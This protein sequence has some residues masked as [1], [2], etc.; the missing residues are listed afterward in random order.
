MTRG[1][2]ALM[3]AMAMF[4]TAML[5]AALPAATP[6][7]AQQ[8]YPARPVRIVMPL[9]AG[10]ALDII[11]RLVGEAMST[12]LGQ[13]VVVENRVGGTGLAAARAAAAA[14]PD[15]YTL[16]GGAA[17]IFT[18]LAA[19]KDVP[20]D[21][22]RDFVQIGL[23]GGGPMY[24]AVS[25]RLE[26]TSLAEFAALAR[27]RPERIVIGTNAAGTLPHFAA[28]ALIRKGDIPA[29]VVPYAG[30]GTAEVIKDMIGGD[31]H[32]TIE[33]MSG[34]RS[35]VRSG[36]V[37]VIA[38]MAPERVSPDI[39]A[40]AETIPGLTAVGWMSLAAPAGTPEPVVQ[41]LN[42]ALGRALA[43]PAV[44]QRLD[45]LGMQPTIMTPAE[46]TAFVARE[47]DF[48]WPVVREAEPQ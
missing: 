19:G 6:A 16:L 4:G 32:A 14:A 37:R 31:A 33:A 40:V 17:F 24:L 45:D 22:D 2:R 21:V 28:L 30:G 18:I 8:A 27:S 36:A 26:V 3:A 13:R 39:P 48:W 46:T 10:S 11:L 20:V 47:Q 42:A 15:G 12:D 38:S 34:L 44:R 23:V 25:T 43:A 29:L 5:G 7:G 9:P 35:A 1:A 41:R